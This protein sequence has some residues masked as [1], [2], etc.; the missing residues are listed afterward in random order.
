MLEELNLKSKPEDR[1]I[2]TRIEVAD[3]E[4]D[5]RM[6]QVLKAHVPLLSPCDAT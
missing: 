1:S 4:K 6:F 3:V 5:E 2:Q